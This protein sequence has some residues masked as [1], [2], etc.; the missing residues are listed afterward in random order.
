MAR[1][2][3]LSTAGYKFTRNTQKSRVFVSGTAVVI[4]WS[5]RMKSLPMAEVDLAYEN[6]H[7]KK[8]GISSNASRPFSSSNPGDSRQREN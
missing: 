2:A 5:A 8:F 1:P 3:F 4:G 7:H 6:E